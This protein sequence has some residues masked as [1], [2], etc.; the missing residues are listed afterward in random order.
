MENKPIAGR[1]K[2]LAQLMELHEQNAFKIKSIA[3]AAF[4][5]D[6]LP[7]KLATKSIEEINQIDGIGKSIAAYIKQLVETGSITDLEDLLKTTPEG[8]V[9]MLHIKGIGPKKV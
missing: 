6:K 3:N 1:L 4:K 7:Y 2:L 8:A 9:E 5:I